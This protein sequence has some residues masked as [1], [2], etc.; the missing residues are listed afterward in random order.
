M[1]S[2][3][4]IIF[5]LAMVVVANTAHEVALVFNNAMLPH[6]APVNMI[7]RISGWAWSMGYAG[8]MVCLVIALVFLVGIGHGKPLLGLPTENAENVRAVAVLVAIWMCVFMVPLMMY[9]EDAKR[10]S[11]PFRQVIGHGLGQLRET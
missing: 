4:N 10:T 1:G 8:G 9:T 3:A 5:V 2:P 6:I 7:G 11:L